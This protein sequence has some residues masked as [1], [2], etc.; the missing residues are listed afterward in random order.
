MTTPENFIFNG[1]DRAASA[2]PCGYALYLGGVQGGEFRGTHQ[3]VVETAQE[4]E[5]WVRG[6]DVAT[7]AV[8]G[9]R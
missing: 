6:E 3:G 1:T 5:A 2:E 8:H 4:A 7:V 9:L